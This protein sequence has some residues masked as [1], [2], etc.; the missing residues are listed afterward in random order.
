MESAAQF[1]ESSLLNQAAAKPKK[2]SP[3]KDPDLKHQGIAFRVRPA[4]KNGTKYFVCDFRV[5]GERKLMWRS[6]YDDAK[7]AA[8]DAIDKIADGQ[9]EVLRLTSANAHE[10]L[11]AK[12][13][14][15]SVDMR[16]DH[17]ARDHAELLKLLAGRTTPI[18]AI[19]D[20]LKRHDAKL[21]E[22]TLLDARDLFIKQMKADGKSWQRIHQLTVVL[23]RF[24]TDN[25]FRVSE[26][27]PDILSRWLAGLGLAEKTRKNHRDVVGFFNRWCIM[28]GYL[29]KGT[30]W[31]EHVQKYSARSHGEIEIYTPD[32]IKTLLSKADKGMVPFLAIGAFAGLRH[33]EIA[34]LDWSEID[35]DDDAA[36]D[37]RA[38]FIEVKAS[39]AKTATRRLVPVKSNLLAWLKL[40]RK[41]SGPVC[42]H[43]NTTKQLLKVADDAKITWKHNA[44]RHS[45]ISYRVAECADVPRVADECGNT[46][47]VIRSNYLQRVKPK[48]AEA[49]FA[50]LPDK[51][52]KP[53]RPKTSK[54]K[55]G[56]RR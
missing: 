10:Y 44:L 34:R 33:A 45:C 32:E 46:P 52:R 49:W 21:P 7:N 24:A 30:D 14:S 18:E 2:A 40:Y 28:R 11:R 31:L 50:L 1:P 35:F 26:V 12:E 23:N 43:I 39:K 3:T 53:S 15:D 4:L 6:S 47:Q 56:K 5:K 36:A 48:Q 13:S 38:A 25:P 51:K 8:K 54:T 16:L 41:E 20:W 29:A 17:L 42:P 37:K 22:I 27:T 9:A 55:V 19:R